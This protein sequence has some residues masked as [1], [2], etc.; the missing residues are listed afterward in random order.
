MGNTEG[1]VVGGSVEISVGSGVG[2][3]GHGP[4]SPAS[5]V[6]QPRRS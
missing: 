4:H 2:E 3:T 1:T 6:E 5:V